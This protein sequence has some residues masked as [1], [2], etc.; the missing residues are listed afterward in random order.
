MTRRPIPAILS[1]IA[2]LFSIL[3]S[4]TLL[5]TLHNSSYTTYNYTFFQETQEMITNEYAK[6]AIDDNT[7][8]NIL[9]HSDSTAFSGNFIKQHNMKAMD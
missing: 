3:D 2:N 7:V 4:T 9:I 6:I 8:D 1:V 5:I